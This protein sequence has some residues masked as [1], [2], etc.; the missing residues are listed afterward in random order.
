[1]TTNSVAYENTNL[2]SYSSVGESPN[3]G[4]TGLNTSE[5]AVLLPEGSQG[6]SLSLPFTVSVIRGRKLSGIAV[7]WEEKLVGVELGYLAE[8]ISEQNVEGAVWFL[9]AK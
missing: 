3:A 4:L 5:S 7:M 1:M 8:E 2:L 9:L 6:G